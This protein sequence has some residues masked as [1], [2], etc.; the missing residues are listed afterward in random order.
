MRTH[1]EVSVVSPSNKNQIK[2][3]IRGDGVLRGFKIYCLD[4]QQKQIVKR[5]EEETK[6]GWETQTKEVKQINKRDMVS[7]Q[8]TSLKQITKPVC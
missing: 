5:C 3:Q 4:L 1:K 7:C 2:N 6:K 8:R